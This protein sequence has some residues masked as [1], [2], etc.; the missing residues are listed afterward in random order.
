MH[1]LAQTIYDSYPSPRFPDPSPHPTDYRR[2][3]SPKLNTPPDTT[4][5]FFK[6]YQPLSVIHPWMRLLQ[7]LFPTHVR[8]VN[9]GT[10]YEGRNILGLR[11]GVH[12]TNSDKPSEAR[13]TIVISGGSHARE[14]ISTAGVSYGAYSLITGYGRSREMTKLMEEFDW[15]FIPTLNP[16]G[17]VY[18]WESD[19]LWRKNRQE[20]NLRFCKGVDLDRS[21]GYQWDG[22]STKGNPCSESFAGDAPFEGVESN[23]FANWIKNETEHNNASFVGFLDFHSYSQQ[24]LYPFSFSCIKTPPT[25]ENLEELGLGLAKA[26]KQA[27]NRNYGVTSA[28]E[29]GVLAS[30]ESKKESKLWPRIESGGGSALDYMYHEMHV[31]YA[32]QI[33]L[34]DRGSY[35]FLLPSKNI[36]P[37]GKEVFNALSYFGRYLLGNKGIETL[38]DS[39]SSDGSVVF[40]KMEALEEVTIQPKETEDDEGEVERLEL[41]LR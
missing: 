28:C 5:I 17:Y 26:I 7:S 6:E 11:V 37:T 1:D 15:V 4:N 14:W 10:T 18:T 21:Y 16:D 22:E 24:I 36:V 19:R 38:D 32:Y 30:R 41:E 31:K 39:P 8:L 3:F 34:R 40:T 2:S 33:K 35:G 27:D 9:I 12:P 23:R 13:K 29:G 20:T 25:L